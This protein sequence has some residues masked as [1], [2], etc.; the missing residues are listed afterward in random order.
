MPP[1]RRS[2]AGARIDLW[3]RRPALMAE[4][5]RQDQMRAGV[6]KSPPQTLEVPHERRI[7]TDAVDI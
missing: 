3:L 7:S 5:H 4:G 2:R 6:S 1:D